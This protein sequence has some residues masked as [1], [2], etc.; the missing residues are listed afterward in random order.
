MYEDLQDCTEE[1]RVKSQEEFQRCTHTITYS[2]NDKINSLHTVKSISS[3]LCKAL[4]NI[5]RNCVHHLDKCL[6]PEDVKIMS[7]NHIKQLKVFFVNLAGDKVKDNLDLDNCDNPGNDKDTRK[8]T[9]DEQ[10]DKENEIFSELKV[11]EVTVQAKIVNIAVAEEHDVMDN[12]EVDT[13]EKITE[14]HLNTSHSS[15]S[16]YLQLDD[17]SL[18]I[19][20]I[21]LLYNN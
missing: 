3:L 5:S 6:D 7:E 15:D 21:V 10:N 19:S 18:M 9:L 14:E 8:T 1:E 2:V 12:L 16:L 20:L 4:S 13:D 17:L 11:M